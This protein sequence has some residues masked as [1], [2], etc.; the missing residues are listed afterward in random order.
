MD[1]SE[2]REKRSVCEKREEEKKAIS[3]M[4]YC[5]ENHLGGQA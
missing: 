5:G 2:K 4:H 1:G 3:C